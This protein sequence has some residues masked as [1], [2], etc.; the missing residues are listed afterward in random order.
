MKRLE[1]KVIHEGVDFTKEVNFLGAIL[2][3]NGVEDID[4]FLNVNKDES[5]ALNVAF[6]AL[7]KE[8]FDA[9]DTVE[10]NEGSN[11]SDDLGV[12]FSA[13]S[14]KEDSFE[15]RLKKDVENRLNKLEEK[16][17]GN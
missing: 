4:S 7:T 3:S 14:D 15:N 10:V 12:D 5:N 17:N 1:Y 11:E 2:E 9:I 6:M 16:E 13:G 8:E